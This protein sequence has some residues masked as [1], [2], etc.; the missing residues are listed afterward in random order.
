MVPRMNSSGRFSS[1]RHTLLF[2]ALQSTGHTGNDFTDFNRC[3][4]EARNKG[5]SWTQ[6]LD[7]TVKKLQAAQQETS[8]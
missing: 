4:S 8:R 2:K 7:Y 6:G 5:L 3:M 1:S